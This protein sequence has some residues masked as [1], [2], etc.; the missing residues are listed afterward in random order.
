[1]RLVDQ[2]VGSAVADYR[3]RGQLQWVRAEAEVWGGRPRRALPLLSDYL[4]GPSGDVNRTFGL[5][6]LAWATREAG[7]PAVEPAPAQSKPI[8]A[9]VPLETAAVG[10]LDTEPAAAAELFERAGRA[11]ASY[12]RRGEVRCR[13]ARGEALRLAGQAALSITVLEEAEYEARALGQVMMLGRVHRSLR[14]L[15][16]RRTVARTTDA[17]GLTG[18]ERE[19]LDLVGKGLTNAQIAA[20]LGVSRST[21]VTLVDSASTKLGATSR[22]HAASLMH[23]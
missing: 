16:V 22:V 11:W 5:I 4:G 13:W 3:G 12:H 17:S 10:L 7:L 2:R 1:L 15:G 18:R 9:A 20:R 23:G 21:V 6:T 8:L 14:R 19:I